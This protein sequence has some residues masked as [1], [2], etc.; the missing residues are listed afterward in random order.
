MIRG[1]ETGELD[2]SLLRLLSECNIQMNCFRRMH[3]MEVMNCIKQVFVD[4]NLVKSLKKNKMVE[5]N[6]KGRTTTWMTNIVI[7]ILKELNPMI[8]D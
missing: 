5:V 7:P 8:K 3:S 1:S 4:L 2:E 6:H